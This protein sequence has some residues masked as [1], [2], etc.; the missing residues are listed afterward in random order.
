MLPGHIAGFYSHEECHI[1]LLRPQFAQAQLYIDRVVG[2]DMENKKVLCANRP[3]VAFD[4]LSID[5]GSI[6][7]TMSVPRCGRIRDR[8]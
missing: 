2:F 4:L 6:P 8:G 1:D 7:A 3:S 5:I